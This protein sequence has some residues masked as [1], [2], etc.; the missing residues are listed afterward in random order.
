[1]TDL[2]K[3]YEEIL[4]KALKP[5]RYSGG[6]YNV[7]NIKD[8]KVKFCL[9]F[10]DVYEV[11]ISNLGNKIIYHMV[12]DS[13][14]FSC[15][16]CYSPWT[17]MAEL[18][19]AEKLPLF[20]L[21]TRTPLGEFDLLGMSLSYEMSYTNVLEMLDLS[22]IPMESKNRSENDPLVFAGGICVVNPEP[23]ANF[24]DFFLLGEGEVNLLPI[25]ELMEK[26]KK[27]NWTRDEFL[28]KV[29]EISFAYVPKLHNEIFENG[30]FKGLENSP[31]MTKA[32][33][34]DFD[35]AYFPTSQIVPNIQAVHDRGV[36]EVFRG[37]PRGCRFCQASFCYRPIRCK[38]KDTLLKEC[39]DIIS[40]CGFD[41]VSLSSLSTGDY[42]EILPLIKEMSAVT[43]QKGVRLSL[44]SLRL[45]SFDE[46][47]VTDMKKT[48]SLTF[49]PEAGTQRLRD[50][51]NKNITTEEFETAMKQAFRVGYKSV[52]LYFMIGLPTETDEDIAG[53]FAMTKRVK[54]IYSEVVHRRDVRVTASVANFVPKPFTPFQ[55][56]AQDTFAEFDR[57]H[58]LLKDLFFKSGFGFKYH[59]TF[60]SKLESIFASC[61]RK[62]GDILLEGYKNG[63]IFD[64][65]SE[66]FSKEG[67]EKALETCGADIDQMTSGFD[68][69]DILPWQFVDVGVTEEFFKEENER[70]KADAVTGDCMEN[71]LG[72]GADRLG[73]CKTCW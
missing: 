9:C 20:S 72:C 16:R 36:L 21:E 51:I 63:C 3:R 24:M 22:N 68:Y 18:L 27:E 40:Q 70:S 23:I 8:S 34:E 11:A 46:D 66:K 60:V 69:N 32:I 58:R 10:P 28:A 53:I 15:E 5:A 59:D 1:M 43:K 48:A 4:A 47:F 38:S 50:V 33:V 71:C 64:G 65:W 62:A 31:I 41:E 44:P 39:D 61:G 7:S 25:L 19:R 67:W 30:V 73:E 2:N 56:E 45:D 55:W 14:K 12:N 54:E 57:K 35:N 13:E 26:K 17:D 49:A 29:D 42:P 6:E 52:K 37:C